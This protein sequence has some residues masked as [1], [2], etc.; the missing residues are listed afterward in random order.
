[1]LLP[2]ISICAS[3]FIKARDFPKYHPASFVQATRP[4][5]D[6]FLSLFLAQTCAT[7]YGEQRRGALYSP[8]YPPHGRWQARHGWSRTL[9]NNFLSP[10]RLGFGKSIDH[11][12]YSF[13]LNFIDLILSSE[14]L[15]HPFKIFPSIHHEPGDIRGNL[16][17]PS[18]KN[19]NQ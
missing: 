16:G 7:R 10:T 8:L 9:A 3:L 19:I 17:G 15:A 12:I 1:M 6:I 5:P 18:E 2:C 11:L 4:H 14:I 13:A